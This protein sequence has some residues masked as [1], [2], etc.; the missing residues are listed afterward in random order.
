MTLRKFNKKYICLKIIK[1]LVLKQILAL[2]NQK[3][4]KEMQQKKEKL[5]KLKKKK[6][7]KLKNKKKKEKIKKKL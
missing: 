1:I 4:H 6:K 2:N 3:I 5:K 7:E